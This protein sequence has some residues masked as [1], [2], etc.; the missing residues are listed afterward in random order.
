MT[1]PASS[2]IIFVTRILT[3]LLPLRTKV[4]QVLGEILLVGCVLFVLGLFYEYG[5][6]VVRPYLQMA[7]GGV[8]FVV[9]FLF[10][11]LLFRVMDSLDE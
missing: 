7:I 11:R 3:K 2:M 4:T 10:M 8:G 6:E 5:P 1:D 9:F